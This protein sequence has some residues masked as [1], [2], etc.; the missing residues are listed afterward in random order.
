MEDEDINNILMPNIGEKRREEK[1][2][3]ERG[4]ERSGMAR[5]LPTIQNESQY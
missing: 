3:R 1:G 2:E 5:R 4:A